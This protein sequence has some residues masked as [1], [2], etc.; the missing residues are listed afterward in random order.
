MTARPIHLLPEVQQPPTVEERR[1]RALEIQVAALRLGLFVLAIY[2]TA[3]LMV[4]LAI[5]IQVVI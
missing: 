2:F 1:V 4:G 3:A 5:V